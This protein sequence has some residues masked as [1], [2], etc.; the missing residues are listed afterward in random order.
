MKL[1]YSNAPAL[2]G[3]NPGLFEARLADLMNPVTVLDAHRAGEE[4]ELR[5]ISNVTRGMHDYLRELAKTSTFYALMDVHSSWPGLRAQ[6][7]IA[8]YSMLNRLMRGA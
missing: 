2:D 7:N 5:V 8:Y 4:A 6:V 3:P 1:D